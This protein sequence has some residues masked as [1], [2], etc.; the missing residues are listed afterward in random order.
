M[1]FKI[2]VVAKASRNLIKKEDQGFKIYLT[3]PAQDGLAN[4]Q[5]VGLL[6]EYLGISK[7]CIAIIKGLKSRD[8]LVK[9]T[10]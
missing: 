1:V 10:E 5:L 3:K 2:R 8:K 4:Q 6:S 7:S 9:I